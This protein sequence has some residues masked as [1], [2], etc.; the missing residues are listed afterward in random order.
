MR[1]EHNYWLKSISKKRKFPRVSL[2]EGV[3]CLSCGSNFK[4]LK[5]GGGGGGG[6]TIKGFN[7][8]WKMNDE[9]EK[10]SLCK[11]V[12][13]LMH[14]SDS[15]KATQI[16]MTKRG[17]FFSESNTNVIALDF[18]SDSCRFHDSLLRRIQHQKCQVVVGGISLKNKFAPNCRSF[19]VRASFAL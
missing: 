5:R 12:I 7:G 1:S 13:I 15:T 19:Q 17:I 4:A 8:E 14:E 16:I 3:V 18:R 11:V 10:E 6:D 9:K 2:W